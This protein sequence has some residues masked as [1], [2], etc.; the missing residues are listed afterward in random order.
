VLDPDAWPVPCDYCGWCRH[1]I[2]CPALKQRVDAVHAG[3]EDWQLANYHASEIEKPEEMGKA[4]ALSKLMEAWCEAVKFHAN[5]MAFQDGKDIPGTVKRTRA[6][7]RFITDTE[8]AFGCMSMDQ[9][10]YLKACEA[11]FTQLVQWF[12]TTHGMSEAKAK[13]EVEKRLGDLLQRKPTSYFL[14]KGK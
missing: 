2:Y 4:F 5:K 7:N 1:A 10:S 9:E 11:K 8:A 12:R 13:K 3:R 6:G 14:K